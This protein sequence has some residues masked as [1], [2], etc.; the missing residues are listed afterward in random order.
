M[1]ERIQLFF[2]YPSFMCIYINIA[3]YLNMIINY[4][5]KLIYPLILEFCSKLF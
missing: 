5:I 4:P 2:N 3:D 1:K